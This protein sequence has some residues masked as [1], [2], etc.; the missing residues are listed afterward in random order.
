MKQPLQLTVS[1]TRPFGQGNKFLNF[2][3]NTPN[4]PIEGIIW[5]QA[6]HS[7]FQ[8]GA[9]LEIMVG[10]DKRND[11]AAWNEYKGKNRLEI[12]RGAEI[13]VISGDNMPST[14][15]ASISGITP[16]TPATTPNTPPT[17]NNSG[18]P[19]KPDE[20]VLEA[21]S[22]WAGFQGQYL[23]FLIQAGF[24]QEGAEASAGRLPTFIAENWFLEK[25]V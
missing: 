5:E 10:T 20:V 7:L 2:N 21:L 16:Q 17:Y 1:G 15:P 24:S 3:A 18:P 9:Q 25:G 4:G 12:G 14:A 23:D 19:R 22:R 13:S 8:N 11:G 6:L